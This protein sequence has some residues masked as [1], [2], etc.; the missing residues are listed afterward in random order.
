MENKFKLTII[1][2]SELKEKLFNTSNVYFD[3]FDYKINNEDYDKLITS[4]NYEKWMHLYDK[5]ELSENKLIFLSNDIIEKLIKIGNICV[6]KGKFSQLVKDE[7][8]EIKIYLE[9]NINLN[10]EYFIKLN[11]ASPKDS[12]YGCK[13]NSILNI[14]ETI[15]TS[16][17]C[18][19][20]VKHTGLHYIVL[21][22]WS[23]NIN[24]KN[25][26]R[27][28][29]YK[30]KI[31]GISQYDWYERCQFKNK[32]LEKIF[33]NINILVSKI[34]LETHYISYIVDVHIEFD[35]SIKFI[36]IN[37]W[38]PSGSCLFEWKRD[39]DQLHGKTNFIEFRILE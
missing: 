29:V 31:T 2:P 13:I 11:S 22:P 30:N 37:P 4:T 9:N 28:F 19:I 10:G 7:I 16:K 38:G 1:L 14:I 39:F 32:N 17:R 21:K 18:M 6:V 15:V 33:D 34:N 26:L 12:P 25:E 5:K 27:I 3:T 35:D 20:S 23:K 8:D 24:I 36:E